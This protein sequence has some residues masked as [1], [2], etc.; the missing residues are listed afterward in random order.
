MDNSP[1]LWLLLSVSLFVF[2]FMLW[3]FWDI[4]S[5][6]LL[7]LRPFV[8][9]SIFSFFKSIFFSNILLL[10]CSILLGVS[11]YFPIQLS[12]VYN[13][14][15][16][17]DQI[18]FHLTGSYLPSTGPDQVLLSQNRSSRFYPLLKRKQDNHLSGHH[19]DHQRSFPGNY[20]H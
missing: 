6:F 20:A 15:S 9:I 11:R 10:C 16:S 12:N 14:H 7:D 13:D 17:G 2:S 19:I 5:L 3:L 4:D 1:M 8:N 18:N